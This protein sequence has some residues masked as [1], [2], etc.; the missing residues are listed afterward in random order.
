MVILL[1]V[2]QRSTLAGYCIHSG[3]QVA[4]ILIKWA[5]PA[6]AERLSPHDLGHSFVSDLIDA[7]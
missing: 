5:A 2:R 1:A 7:G 4:V 3:G 6:G